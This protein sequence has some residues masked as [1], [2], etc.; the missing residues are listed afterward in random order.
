MF[1]LG[2]NSGPPA[3]VLQLPDA[4]LD[5]FNVALPPGEASRGEALHA[6]S[7]SPRMSTIAIGALLNAC[8]EA[9]PADHAF[10]NVGVWNGFTFLSGIAGNPDKRCIGVDDF[11]EFGGPRDAFMERFQGEQP[12][13]TPAR[14]RS[15]SLNEVCVT[16]AA[17]SSMVTCSDRPPRWKIPALRSRVL[18]REGGRELLQLLGRGVRQR[19]PVPEARD[20]RLQRRELADAAA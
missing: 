3:R 12:I 5:L 16:Y 11:S 15:S 9:M 7:V 6:M 2:R 13:R 19:A 17:G 4:D 20:P 1:V 18:G 10:V 14:R 8:V